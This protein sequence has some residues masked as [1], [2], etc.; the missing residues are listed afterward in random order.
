M[1]TE[2]TASEVV[3]IGNAQEVILGAKSIGQPDVQGRF[4]PPDNDLDD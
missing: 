2:Y 1:N 3:E 4:S